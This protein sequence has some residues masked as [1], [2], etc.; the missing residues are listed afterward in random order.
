MVMPSAIAR[1][2]RLRGSDDS[3][4]EVRRCTYLRLRRWCTSQVS[5]RYRGLERRYGVLAPGRARAAIALLRRDIATLLWL[6][7]GGRGSGDQPSGC[8]LEMHHHAVKPDS[9]RLTPAGSA[10]WCGG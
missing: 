5:P 1:H 8:P 3:L 6:T 9:V 7:S 10:N 4:S 2:C